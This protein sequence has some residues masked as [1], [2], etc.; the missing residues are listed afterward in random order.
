MKTGICI[1]TALLLVVSSASAAETLPKEVFK[2]VIVP[3]TTIDHTAGGTHGYH[4]SS[5]MGR[6]AYSLR[7][8]GLSTELKG[9]PK[10]VQ[11]G[12]VVEDGSVGRV[13]LIDFGFDREYYGT[14]MVGEP[15]QAFKIDFD[16]GSSKF[17][18]STKGC[19]PCSG[20]SHYDP[21][22]SNTFRL[23]GDSDSNIS[24]NNTYSKSNTW[25]ITYGDMSQAEGY[26][27]Q[28]HVMIDNLLIK[29]QQLALV[30]RESENF[31]EVIDGIMGLSFGALS[32]SSRRSESGTANANATLPSS[33]SLPSTATALPMT[34]FENMMDQGLVDR[35]I[36][37]FYLGKAT[38]GG[39]GELIFGGMDLDR[40]Q[41]GHEIVYTPV[42]K[43]KYWEINVENIY[44]VGKRVQYRS[45][46]SVSLINTKRDV[47]LQENN[48]DT[49]D[50]NIDRSDNNK[51][52][53]SS[54]H[55]Q[56]QQ[57]RATAS[58][59]RTSKSNIAGIVDTGT[60]LLIVPV[61]LSVAIHNLIPG[62]HVRDQSWILPCDL[63][64]SDDHS[65]DKDD[66]KVELEIEG[67]KF[68]IPFEDLVREPIEHDAADAETTAEVKGKGRDEKDEDPSLY[69]TNSGES[70]GEG[71]GRV[72]PNS[73][74]FDSGVDGVLAQGS[75][76]TSATEAGAK[77]R[78]AASTR[79]NK[80]GRPQ[81]Q[82]R[83]CFSGIQASGA[84]FM[85]IGDLFIKNN[86][87][88]F[89]QEKQQVGF[90]PLKLAD[91]VDS[92]VVKGAG[93]KMRVGWELDEDEA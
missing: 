38:R 57:K 93:V 87:V 1:P 39:G 76:S 74:F 3:I 16:T 88:V 12:Q 56:R 64:G 30:T 60:T 17:I 80:K 36:F 65:K 42:T 19:N 21:A 33:S 72:V 84:N 59:T 63:V 29:N 6:W 34:V 77:S 49:D 41:K 25:R 20:T 5:T 69:S 24:G 46:R 61:R 27:G 55:Q 23:Y 4:R 89:D 71:N 75:S 78:R 47:N 50:N 82:P 53:Q 52:Q 43:T 81:V 83:L 90:A 44:V 26:F 68:A 40:I 67:H 51:H 7:K 11:R 37:S 8:Y 91:R 73:V 86:Y 79:K 66:R 14:V 32:S 2:Q 54:Q 15:P 48:N 31:D 45:T 13:P 92:Q 58:L 35:G 28:D 18:L 70:E 85:I 9:G 22:A 62:A 10:S